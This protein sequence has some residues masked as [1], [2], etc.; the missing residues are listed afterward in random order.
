MKKIVLLLLITS[1]SFSCSNKKEKT[2]VITETKEVVSKGKFKYTPA[3]TKL[4]WTAYKTPKKVGV[5]GTFDNIKVQGNKNSDNIEDVLTGATFVIN[6]LSVNSNNDIRDPKLVKFF[7]KNLARPTFKGE[8]GEFK[9]GNVDVTLTFNDVENVSAFKYTIQDNELKI[10]GSIDILED[11]KAKNAFN[12]I[13]EACNQ[14][15]EGK[16]WTD[17][18]I[19]VVTKM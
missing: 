7:F 12:A 8:F 1:L 10:N 4:T 16:T 13:H 3:Q 5:S 19:E 18:S 9:N 15:H 11:F 6:G 17:V 14:L 2:E